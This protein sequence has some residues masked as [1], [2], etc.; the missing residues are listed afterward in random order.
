MTSDLAVSAHGLTKSF[1]DTKA[2]CG[3][4]LQIPRGSVLGVLGPNGA[5]KTTAVRIL[6]TL[7]RA[8]A[9]EAT[10]LGFDVR[11]QPH[12]VRQRIG[13]A[14]QAAS[15]DDILSGRQ[16]LEL[17]GRLY[18]LD[19]RS[20]RRRADELLEQFD[21]AE[22]A[23]R[24]AKEYSG[25]MRRRLDLAAA[26]VAEPALLVLDE[27]TTGLD[28]RSRNDLWDVLTGL[29]DGGA[30]LLLTTQ[31]LEEADRLADRI[32]VI[33]HG[34][35]IAEGTASQ[36]KREV[37][38]ERVAVTASEAHDLAKVAAI[39]ETA[40]GAEPQVDRDARQVTAAVTGLDVLARVADAL[41]SAGVEVDDLGLHRPTLDDVFLQ[42]T[43]H[44]AV[45][46]QEGT[47]P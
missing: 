42:L 47:Q 5:G 6:T 30:T 44:L 26:L 24:P 20:R 2:L 16:N 32:A 23:D 17:V 34:S 35:V 1:G 21:L 11:T 19:S 12:E 4:D 9:G 29:V 36:L 41:H 39:V 46:N 13:L 14:G 28:P 27:P 25:G 38:G 43:G 40:T 18:H 33:D 45:D 15:V 31:Y 37:G 7:L 10:V 22:A 8:D 3:I